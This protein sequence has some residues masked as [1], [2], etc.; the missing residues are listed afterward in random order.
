ML[1]KQGK[2]MG[3]T[4]DVLYAPT[5]HIVIVA[6]DPVKEKTEGGIVIMESTQ[7][8]D[9]AAQTYGTVLAMGPDCFT[10]LA[11]PTRTKREADGTEVSRKAGT[12][13]FA[14]GSRV[15]YQRYA[16]MRV[17]GPD[18][19]LRKDIILLNEQDITAVVIGEK[20]RPEI[21][22]H[23]KVYLTGE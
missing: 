10:D 9:A 21:P 3:A 12:Q 18:G 14:V 20:T 7:E 6:P 4:L 8:D 1:T 11:G 22:E 13:I 16:G 19:N 15:L 5:G 23:L 17:P 2:I